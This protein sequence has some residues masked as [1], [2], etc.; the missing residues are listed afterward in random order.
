MFRVSFRLINAYN[1]KCSIFFHMLF[2]FSQY[3][4]TELGD[5]N[6]NCCLYVTKCVNLFVFFLDF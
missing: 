4:V 3:S 1:P 6:R 2:V 5:Y